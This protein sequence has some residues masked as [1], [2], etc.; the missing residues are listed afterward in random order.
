MILNLISKLFYSTKKQ[1]YLDQFKVVYKTIEDHP[2]AKD[3][4]VLKTYNI[5]EI[6]DQF[7]TTPKSTS[8]VDLT[9]EISKLKLDFGL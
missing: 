6:L 5:R 9:F 2:L 8:L 4:H 3:P 1:D 7:S